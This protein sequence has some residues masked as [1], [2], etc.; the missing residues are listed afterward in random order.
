M[1]TAKILLFTLTTLVAS[2]CFGQ[3]NNPQPTGQRQRLDDIAIDSDDSDI[4][5][6]PKGE[7]QKNRELPQISVIDKLLSIESTLGGKLRR[8]T[9]DQWAGTYNELYNKFKEDGT[10]TKIRGEGKNMAYTA[11]AL[12]IK[13][14]DGVL[15]LKA[16][17]IEALKAAADQIEV[18]AKKLGATQGELGMANTVKIYANKSQWFNAFLALGRL[19]R[20]V[21]NY[22]RSNPEK[23]DQAVLVIVGGWL[24]GGRI[25]THVI[26]ENYDENVS[27]VLREQKLVDMIQENMEK[28]APVYLNDPLVAEIIK[29]LPSIRKRVDVG[30]TEP[31]KQDDVKALYKTF[32]GFVKKIMS[33]GR[34]AK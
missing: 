29:E 14:S 28:L 12:G 8:T 32:E 6:V 20:D 9:E 27:N 7:R 16:R 3:G 18:L 25:V 22:L 24:Q 11:M 23:T 5:A 1:T 4:N 30:F 21:L 26:D 33:A 31:V 2:K 15:A 19:Q 34:A 10:P 13:A 17:N